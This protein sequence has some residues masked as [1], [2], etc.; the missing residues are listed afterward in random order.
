MKKWCG[1]QKSSKSD[2]YRVIVPMLPDFIRDDMIIEGNIGGK[3]LT[4]WLNFD[5]AKTACTEFNALHEKYNSER[6]SL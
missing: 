3:I 1:I 5:E 2:R 4:K 6:D